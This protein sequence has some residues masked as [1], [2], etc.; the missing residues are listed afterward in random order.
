MRSLLGA[1]VQAWLYMRPQLGSLFLVLLWNNMTF[2]I[3]YFHL[4]SK[5][6]LKS[7]V[8]ITRAH[9]LVRRNFHNSFWKCFCYCCEKSLLIWLNDFPIIGLRKW[10]GEW[11]LVSGDRWVMHCWSLLGLVRMNLWLLAVWHKYVL[12]GREQEMDLDGKPKVDNL[13]ATCRTHNSSTGQNWDWWWTTSTTEMTDHAV[14][15]VSWWSVS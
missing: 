1:A 15:G 8:W 9:N 2:L 12:R 6:V 7:M 3:Y 11:W 14:L 4:I 5:L 13:L 10:G